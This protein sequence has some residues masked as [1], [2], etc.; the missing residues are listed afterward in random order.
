MPPRSSKPTEKT[1]TTLMH[2]EASRRNIPTAEFESLMRPEQQ[3]P[4]RVAYDRRNRDLD[5]QTRERCEG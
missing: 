2:D 5:H 1:V 4:V 3:R